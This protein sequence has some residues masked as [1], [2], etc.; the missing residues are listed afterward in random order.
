MASRPW[1]ARLGEDALARARGECMQLM[2][3]L[4]AFLEHE[5]DRPERLAEG[6]RI[7][8][9]LGREVARWGLTPAQSTEVFVHF[10]MMVTDLLAAPP[11]GASG[12]IRSMRDA[13][14]FLGEVLQAMMEAYEQ[15]R[16]AR[17]PV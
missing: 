10:K 2:H 5:T 15:E 3:A 17:G 13:D 9:G 14:A 1:F 4:T 6:R 11:L 12:Q 8:A 16:P 7:G